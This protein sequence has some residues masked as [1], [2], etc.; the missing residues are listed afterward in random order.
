VGNTTLRKKHGGIGERRVVLLDNEKTA[1]GGC[2]KTLDREKTDQFY[3][4]L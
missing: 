3:N 1:E 2:K 4:T